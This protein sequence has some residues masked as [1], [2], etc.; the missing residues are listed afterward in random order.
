MART[1]KVIFTF[2][3]VGGAPAI[4]SQILCYD[5]R[6]NMCMNDSEL[7]KQPHN[8]S[9]CVKASDCYVWYAYNCRAARG[10]QDDVSGQ[11]SRTVP[12]LSRLPSNN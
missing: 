11:M 3:N 1:A 8:A 6:D 10:W 5:V 4:F 2:M 7:I 9:S 12:S